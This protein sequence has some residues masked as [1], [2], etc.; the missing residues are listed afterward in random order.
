MEDPPKRVFINEA[1]CEGCGDC[2]TQSN[3]LSVVPVETEFGRKRAIDQSSCNKDYSCLKGFCPSFVTVTGGQLRKPAKRAPDDA[4][5]ADLPEPAE[6]PIDQPCGLLVTGIGGTGVVTIGALIGMAAHLEGKGVSV[7]DATGLAQKGGAVFSHIRVARRQDELHA[8]RIAAGEATLLLGCDLVVA[9]SAEALAKLRRGSSRA[10]VNA[11]ETIT[12]A[13]T[14]NPDFALPTTELRRQIAEATGE[15]S[16]EFIDASGIATALLGDSLATNLFLLGFACQKGLVPVS[17]AAILRAIE[18]N[19][20]AIDFNKQAF[21]WG[22]RAAW[23]R[24]AVEALAAPKPA[25]QPIGAR[26]LEELLASRSAFLERYQNRAYAARYEAT[27]KRVAAI[28]AE[29]TAGRKIAEAV[30]DSLFRLMAYKDEYE[31]ARLYTDGSFRRA[32][33]EEFEGDYRVDIQ[34]APPLLAER[35]PVTGHLK[36]RSYGPW[37]LG[38]FAILARLKGLR[39]TR[40]DPF[41]YTAERRAERRLISEFEALIEE[42]LTGLTKANSATA[43]ALARL[44][45]RIRGFGH[46]KDAAIAAAKAEEQ[47]LLALF[48]APP[49]RALAAE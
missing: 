27:V 13:F 43:L 4:A 42:L 7:L 18:L 36:K 16:A 25:A 11:H 3:C 48:R 21:L 23:R 40:F 24:E 5:F 8:V 49:A 10:I 1:V 35:D 31:V 39:G 17:A 32:I 41:G 20:T 28:E 6:A 38:A 15:A 9:A 34:L 2:S 19:G 46:V 22:R 33:A 26:S 37:M 14:R 30:A 29:R 47:R 45:Q 12:G 44:P